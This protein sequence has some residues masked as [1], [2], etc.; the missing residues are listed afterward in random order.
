MQQ[1]VLLFQNGAKLKAHPSRWA[2]IDQVTKELI[3]R[4]KHPAFEYAIVDPVVCLENL[5]S[6]LNI[7]GF[8]CIIDLT[9]VLGQNL[10]PD[11]PRVD[12]FHLSR[13]RVISSP[14]LDGH[15]FLINLSPREVDRIKSTFDLSR[16]LFLDD[17]SWSGRT[18]LEA[19]KV[20]S[21][22]TR[23]VSAGL[24]VTNEGDFG[25]S[26]PGAAQLLREQ[27]ISLFTGKVV[28]SPN[29]D[30]FHLADFSIPEP[31]EDVFD[32]FIQIQKLREIRMASD[33]VRTKEI[34]ITI[35]QILSEIRTK[36]F[37]NA[38]SS[39]EVQQL[40]GEERLIAAGGIR[41]NAHFDINPPS[42]LMPSFSRRVSSTMLQS[43]RDGIINAIRELRDIM[44]AEKEIHRE[45]KSEI[46][47]EVSFRS[48]R[49]VER[50]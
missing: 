3:A 43:N 15:G 49:G 4:I 33:Q 28:F 47:P 46:S 1:K 31:T 8:S 23:C 48:S 35:S 7:A 32:T 12:N 10:D 42:W 24:L 22:D 38:L 29:E 26:N 20:L 27:G 17:V 2:D 44:N 6:N 34:D 30:G 37:P 13:L 25:E 21:I 41:K 16:P 11:I 18:I 9:R 40:Q 50:F 14:R 39:E 45:P 5:F 36:V 19:A